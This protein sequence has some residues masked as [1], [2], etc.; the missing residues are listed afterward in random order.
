MS[1][2]F[3]AGLRRLPVYLLLDCSYSMSGEPIDAL[4]TGISALLSDLQTDP[5]ALETVWLSV[6]TFS[7]SATQVVPLT[8]I[9][10]FQEPNIQVQ[11]AA[12]LGAGLTML[13]DCIDREIRKTTSTQEGDFKPMIFLI[14]D[15]ESTDSWKGPADELKKRN[16]NLIACA[17]GRYADETVLKQITENVIRLQ[18]TS[19]GPMVACLQWVCESIKVTSQSAS[20]Q[21]DAPVNLPALP[22]DHGIVTVP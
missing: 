16:L 7:S 3:S 6:I 20:A 14:T 8:E 15:G 18:D 13:M 5:Q 11:G 2:E 22:A 19:T 17:V 21:G 12:S 10:A 1:D 4:R 9:G